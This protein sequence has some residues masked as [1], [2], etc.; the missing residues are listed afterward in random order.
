MTE[1]P[2][3]IDDDDDNN[4]N[5]DPTDL[6]DHTL[7]QMT[8]NDSGIEGENINRYT[9]YITAAAARTGMGIAD[10]DPEDT[11]ISQGDDRSEIARSISF[12]LEILKSSSAATLDEE[13][14]LGPSR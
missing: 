11:A 10:S 4:D 14:Q 13:R 1:N 12:S 7:Y 2:I 5:S 3:A 8:V 6:F 9:G